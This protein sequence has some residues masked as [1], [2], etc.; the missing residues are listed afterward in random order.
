MESL[1]RH[2]NTLPIRRLPVRGL[3]P[4]VDGGFQH[5]WLHVAISNKEYVFIKTRSD[6]SG[7]SWYAE[8]RRSLQHPRDASTEWIWFG[9]LDLSDGVIY[10]TP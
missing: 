7:V 1:K 5:T 9:Y 4:V 3:K 10:D 6:A 8:C 2:F